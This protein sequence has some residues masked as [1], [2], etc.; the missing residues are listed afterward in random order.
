MTKHFI[1]SAAICALL[2]FAFC[3]TV[4][5]AQ[6]IFQESGKVS[7]P[8]WSGYWWPNSKGEILGPLQKYDLLTSSHSTDWLR[9]HIGGTELGW[10]GLCHGFSAASAT[11]PEPKQSIKVTYHNRQAVLSVGDQKGLLSAAHDDDAC[12]SFG[13]R[14][15][16]DD[17]A[18]AFADVNPIHFW[19]ILHKYV[20]NLGRAVVIDAEAGS[21]VW[22]YPVY[23]YRIT[24]RPMRDLGNGRISEL[25]TLDVLMADD[26]VFPDFVGIQPI[27]QTYYFTVNKVGGKYEAKSAR[28]YGP[29]VKNH[30]DFVWIPEEAACENPELSLELVRQLIK[31]SNPRPEPPTPRFDDETGDEGSVVGSNVESTD[32]VANEDDEDSGIS[33]FDET[34]D[35]ASVVSMIE[36]KTS[37]FNFDVSVEG[38]DRVLKVGDE[39]KLNFRSERQGYLYVFVV[40][41]DDEIFLA[42]PLTRNLKPIPEKQLVK[43]PTN[44]RMDLVGQFLIKAVVLERPLTISGAAVVDEA[45]LRNDASNVPIQ[46]WGKVQN[47]AKIQ[48]QV[49]AINLSGLKLRVAPAIKSTARPVAQSARVFLEKL[50][51]FA[52]DEETVYVGDPKVVGKAQNDR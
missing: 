27:K 47:Q 35:Y 39:L 2:A 19:L 50:G 22:N 7:K 45:S 46:N 1:L 9:E 30:P 38:L 6:Q 15:W 5:D 41:S 52:H 3:P 51:A 18:A 34:V 37:S 44:L 36:N 12:L 11:E 16:G 42:Y 21:A 4:V 40:D 26:A 13:S 49:A 24:I 17:D 25:A 43:L 8:V 29:S 31:I 23:S 20:L 14:Y 48:S 32:V 28:W 33:E 10:E